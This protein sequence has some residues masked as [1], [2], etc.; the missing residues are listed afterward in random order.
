MEV[1]P[2]EK[3]RMYE[4]LTSQLD[5]KS[6]LKQVML[7]HLNYGTTYERHPDYDVEEEDAQTADN[8]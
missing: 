6:M 3:A 7:D 5:L 2:V 1:D 4:F 8:E